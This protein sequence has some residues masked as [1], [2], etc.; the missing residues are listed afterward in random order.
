[1]LKFTRQTSETVLKSYRGIL[2]RYC[3]LLLLFFI[4]GSGLLYAG[5]AEILLFGE[6]QYISV[7]ENN[8]V[9]HLSAEGHRELSLPEDILAVSVRG[10][11]L[12][13]L[14]TEPVPAEPSDEKKEPSEDNVPLLRYVAGLYHLKNQK[15]LAQWP[16]IDLPPGLKLKKSIPPESCFFCITGKKRMKTMVGEV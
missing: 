16:L 14:R 3:V 12:F 15:V 8:K 1:M 10:E 11:K 2:C 6:K 7:S 5:P 4:T 9:L 13:Y